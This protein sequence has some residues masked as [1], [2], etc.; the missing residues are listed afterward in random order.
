[1]K[2]PPAVAG[3]FYPSNPERLLRMIEWTF[4]N[5]GFPEIPKPNFSG[6]RKIRGLMVPH[7]G[8]MYSGPTAAKAYQILAEDGAP[9]T[10]IIIGPNH[11]GMGGAISI[12][13]EGVWETPLGE[14]ELDSEIGAMIERSCELVEEDPVAHRFEHS[15]EV[16]IPF[17]QAI[18]G[19]KFRIVPIMMLAQDLETSKLLG[20]AISEAISSSGRDAV[21]IASSDLTHYEPQV[22]A[23]R[24][25]SHVLSA[26]EKMSENEIYEKVVELNISMCGYGPVMTMIVGTKLLGGRRIVILDYKTSGDVTGD[27]SAVVGYASAA[28]YTE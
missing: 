12:M 22:E 26:I 16:Q 11:V 24:K 13:K 9:E 23:K 5:V 1:M 20:R 15:I 3:Q 14:V 18:Y 10:F 25:D 4:N 19:N 21:I 17:L 8:Y 2:R 27:Y 28:V 7:A 6:P